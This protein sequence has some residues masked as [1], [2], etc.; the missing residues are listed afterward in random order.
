MEKETFL[1]KA[2]E[3]AKF[4]EDHKLISY[5]ERQSDNPFYPEYFMAL[6]INLKETFLNQRP[7]LN[8]L[9]MSNG[10]MTVQEY[11]PTTKQIEKALARKGLY[12]EN[13][14]SFGNDCISVTDVEGDNVLLGEDG[15]V[16]FI[17]PI[18]NFKKSVHEILANSKLP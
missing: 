15:N 18:I 7:N 12:R 16:M 5:R 9:V 10:L 4:C 14:Y 11:R 13:R 6:Q 3:A 8:N 17:D 1:E 2:H